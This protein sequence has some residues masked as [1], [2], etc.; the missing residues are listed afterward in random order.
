MNQL[1]KI[2]FLSVIILGLI[3]VPQVIVATNVTIKHQASWEKFF[4]EQAKRDE[5]LRKAIKKRS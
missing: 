5:E 1:L 3:V 2:I 4:N